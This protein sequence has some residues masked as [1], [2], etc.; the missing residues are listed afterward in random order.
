[1]IVLLSIIKSERNFRNFPFN[2]SF[3]NKFSPNVDEHWQNIKLAKLKSVIGNRNFIES[4]RKKWFLEKYLIAQVKLKLTI[5]KM[6]IHK[7]TRKYN[8]KYKEQEIEY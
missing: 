8:T 7:S 2:S 1:M 6:F 5:L 3:L 4:L